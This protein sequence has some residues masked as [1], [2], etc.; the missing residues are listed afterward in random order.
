LANNISGRYRT[1]GASQLQ[2]PTKAN[3]APAA[4]RLRVMSILRAAMLSCSSGSAVQAADALQVKPISP[5]VFLII[6]FARVNFHRTVFLPL[7]WLESG[8]Y[9]LRTHKSSSLDTTK[10]D[11]RLGTTHTGWALR[12]R[13]GRVQ[14][15]CMTAI[16]RRNLNIALGHATSSV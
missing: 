10:P 7:P 6:C 1:P 16:S 5:K 2:A 4:S 8:H 14:M 13:C 15:A 3:H 12:T 11:L 9:H